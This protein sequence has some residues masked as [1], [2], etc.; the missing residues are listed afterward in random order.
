MKK[1]PTLFA[2][3]L[4]AALLAFGL[5]PFPAAAII[6][7]V[8]QCYQE[9]TEWC[10][11]GTSQAVLAFY[12]TNVAQT[13]IALYGT[14]GSNTWN[15]LY[16]S[17]TEVGVFRRGVDMILS[18]FAA[19]VSTG[20][21][22]LLSLGV[23]QS[24]INTNKRPVVI[25]WGWDS[26]PGTG[27]ILV[28]HGVAI[29]TN[30]PIC[31]TNIW[32]MDP[33][34]G[35][36]VNSYA[37]VCAGGGHTWTHTLPIS[38]PAPALQVTTAELNFGVVEV[39]SAADQMFIL[40]NSGGGW[41]VGTSSVAPPF[42]IVS[43]ASY[44]LP[45]LTGTMGYVRYSPTAPGTNTETVTFTGGGGA[46]CMATGVASLFLEEA[47]EAPYLIIDSGPTPSGPFWKRDTAQT[48]DDV[49]SAKS[50]TVTAGGQS[51]FST[52][53][54]GP[55]VAS[56]WWKVSSGANGFLSFSVGG[57][58]QAVISGEVD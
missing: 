3:M 49:D 57:L 40:E 28:M 36:T 22:N 41:V 53:V 17:G 37:W 4:G 45:S 56:F 16:G 44:R 29:S 42:G 6:L 14:G 32:L 33:L 11:A 54:T 1:N 20:T 52:T 26:A 12:G 43:G 46:S 34:N 5:Q 38:T 15:Y 55:G 21:N 31:F 47:V 13:N 25:R 51:W 7:D 35:P 19:I 23:V 10:W 27:H 9:K 8:P 48:H 2:R 58:Q 30:C 18:N 50:G 24:E 39:G